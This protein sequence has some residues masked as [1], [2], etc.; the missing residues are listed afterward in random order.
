MTKI[1]KVKNGSTDQVKIQCLKLFG[2]NKN[3]FNLS[4]KHE[5]F[6]ESLISPTKVG[7]DFGKEFLVD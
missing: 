6:T 1:G 2:A 7:V 4:I 3:G 5:L